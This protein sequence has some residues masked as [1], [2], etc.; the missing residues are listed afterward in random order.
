MI[1]IKEIAKDEA[2]LVSL[3]KGFRLELARLN[4]TSFDFEASELEE[5][6]LSYFAFG[7]KVLGAFTEGEMVGF[8]VIKEDQG[9][10]WLEWIYVSKNYRG[11]SCAALLFDASEQYAKQHGEEKL[12][13][14]VHPDNRTMLKFLKKKGY[15]ALN[16]IEVTKKTKTKGHEV[17]VLGSTLKY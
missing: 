16:L 8:S 13:I 7:K 5:E 12:Y 14:W 11:S 17:A 2:S 15:D 3:V 10:F 1:T 4:Q 6:S 9:I